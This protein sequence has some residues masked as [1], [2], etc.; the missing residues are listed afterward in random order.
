MEIAS[1][2]S[3]TGRSRASRTEA[4]RR[5][6]RK[7]NPSVAGVTVRA[8]SSVTACASPR[9]TCARATANARAARTTR[10]RTSGKRSGRR[11]S[12]RCRR[13][14]RTPS[15]LASAPSTVRMRRYT[16]RGA[17]A[18]S[19]AAA[20]G[21]ASASRPASSAPRSASAANAT[22]PPA[23]IR[24]RSQRWTAP[25]AR[26]VNRRSSCRKK[27]S[28]EGFPPRAARSCGTRRPSPPRASRALPAGHSIRFPLSEA[29]RA[30]CST[31]PSAASPP[32]LQS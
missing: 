14:S 2:C 25:R 32:L 20:S 19:R 27:N 4:S 7:A 18:R 1:G 13:R 9:G 17:T 16:P 26:W 15:S 29:R 31:P 6:K 3:W 8:A 11:P 12:R 21:T 28:W 23:S 10:P 5:T 24:S 30:P 22:T